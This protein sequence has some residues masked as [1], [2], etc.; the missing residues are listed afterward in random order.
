[1]KV[2]GFFSSG[3]CIRGTS[4]ALYDYADHNEKI[5]S[6]KTFILLQKNGNHDPFALKR[7]SDRF[8]IVWVDIHNESEK[9]DIIKNHNISIIYY[10]RY[11]KRE[12]LLSDKIKNVIHC[13]FDMSEP[14]GDVYAGVSQALSNKFGKNLFVPHMIALQKTTEDNMRKKLN[15]P[16]DAIVFGRYGGMDTFNLDFCWRA[17]K[18]ILSINKNIYF[19]FG[20]TPQYIIHDNI[21][22][23]D[24][25]VTEHEKNLFINTCDAH[26]ECGNLGHSFGLAIGEFSVFNKP[27]IAYKK[28]LIQFREWRG[29]FWNDS[30]IKI[31]GEKGIYFSNEKEFLNILL[32]FKRENYFGKDLNLY[33]EY[34][35]EKVMKIFKEVFID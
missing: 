33:R 6:N 35:P 13:V 23:I 19:L 24:K 29:E 21:K 31:L 16:E 28:P 12:K 22:Y 7:F 3:L 32:T 20:N 26:L 25:I 5:L 18:L 9:D 14:Y 8:D 34:S 1:M 10:I 4:V 17:I 27:I 11:G 15:I 2:I 30:H